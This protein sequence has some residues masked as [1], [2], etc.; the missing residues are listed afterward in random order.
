MEGVW[1]AYDAKT[2]KPIYQRVKVIDRVEHPSLQP[3]KP[4]VVYPSSIGGLNYSPASYD[5][6]TN[7]IFNAAAETAACSPRQATTGREAEGDAR[8]RRLPRARERR[9]RLLPAERLARL[10]LGQRDRRRHRA[11]RVEVQH[12]RARARRRDDDC[13]RPRLRRRRR[14]Q[15]ARLRRQDR[16][17]A[18]EV[19]DRP[20]D[21]LRAVDLLGQRHRVRRDHRRRHGDLV[22]GGTV[23]SQ[24]QVFSL[25]AN[26]AQSPSFTIS[27]EANTGASA[28]PR[29]IDASARVASKQGH[30]V[31]A[32]AAGSVRIATPQ[33][34]TVKAWD[35][36]SNNTQDAQGHIFLAGKPVAGV[37]VSVNGWVAPA[38]DKS[39]AFTYPVDITMADRH[40]VSVAGVSGATI[41]GQ[42]VTAAQRSA[43]LAAKGGISVG[44]GISDLSGG[45]MERHGRRQRAA[46]VRHARQAP[47]PVG[48][49]SYLSPERQRSPYADGSL[50]QGDASG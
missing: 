19:P 11:A 22:G 13:L 21:R 28:P 47:Q 30:A 5:P 15:P 38:T 16:Q 12:A 27:F 36:N 50:G 2:G 10:R 25:G 7:Y 17:R 42:P 1:F 39:G 35:P 43:L 48:L 23:A 14:R 29:R 34:L 37:S 20:P 8:R 49:Y 24:L 40:V 45:G 44:Y 3:G 32:K 41:D 33:G 26:S 31:S 4:V 9:F 18:L 6:K 46:L